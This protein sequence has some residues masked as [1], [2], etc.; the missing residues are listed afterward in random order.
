MKRF[1]VVTLSLVMVLSLAACGGGG[2]GNGGGQSES[3]APNSSTQPTGQGGSTAEDNAADNQ[4]LPFDII[5]EY[6]TNDGSSDESMLVEAVPGGYKVTYGENVSEVL[7]GKWDKDSNLA[8]LE[9]KAALVKGQAPAAG[10]NWNVMARFGRD[11]RGF[12]NGSVSFLDAATNDESTRVNGNFNRLTIRPGVYSYWNAPWKADG[13][14]YDNEN[15]VLTEGVTVE[16][17]NGRFRFILPNGYASDWVSPTTRSWPTYFFE[18]IA[19]TG[20]NLEPTT[21]TFH[22]ECRVYCSVA[23]ITVFTPDHSGYLLEIN[24]AFS[25]LDK[26][27]ALDYTGTY[28]FTGDNGQK[29][30]IVVDKEGLTVDDR[31]KMDLTPED[32]EMGW[33]P[34]FL[35]DTQSGERDE[36]ALTFSN[37]D[38]GVTCSL[39]TASGSVQ[40]EAAV[41]K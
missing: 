9:G 5:G 14:G 31:Y 4:T 22:L 36:A 35:V 32:V 25:A 39:Y 16:Y 1:L 23:Y 29:H 41:R 2:Q 19:V 38:E 21:A 33:R 17:D 30:I 37:R 28:E 20:A 27:Y 34:L 15:A 10:S 13:S 6:V 3:S 26:E 24:Q 7:T 12:L 18:E 40:I 11:D 8:V